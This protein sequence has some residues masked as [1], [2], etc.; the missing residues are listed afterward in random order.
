MLTNVQIY[1]CIP[2]TEGK[3]WTMETHAMKLPVQLFLLI[4]MPEEVWSSAVIEVGVMAPFYGL[5]AQVLGDTA[6]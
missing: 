4:L 2:A 3:A 6:L 5:C 1:E